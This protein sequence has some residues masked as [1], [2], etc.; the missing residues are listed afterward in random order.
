MWDDLPR[1][2]QSLQGTKLRDTHII[3]HKNRHRELDIL[4]PIGGHIIPWL[5]AIVVHLDIGHGDGLF[6]ELLFCVT[7]EKLSN[8]PRWNYW[9]AKLRIPPKAVF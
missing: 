1:K 7:Y 9:H 4:K 8:H 5:A 2:L 3:V 6:Y